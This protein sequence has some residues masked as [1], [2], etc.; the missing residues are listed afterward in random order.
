MTTFE[1]LLSLESFQSFYKKVKLKKNTLYLSM[2]KDLRLRLELIQ[3]ALK[4]KNLV[5]II[6]NYTAN[7]SFGVVYELKQFLKYDYED[8]KKFASTN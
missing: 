6:F 5:Y 4:T 1:K 2:H 3:D 8:I 7:S